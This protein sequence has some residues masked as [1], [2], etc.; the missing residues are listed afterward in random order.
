MRTS[1]NHGWEFCRVPNDTPLAE[2]PAEAWDK[3]VDAVFT[4]DAVYRK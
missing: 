4:E 3:P 1:F 2:V